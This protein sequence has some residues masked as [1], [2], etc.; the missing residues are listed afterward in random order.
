MRNVKL[1]QLI[2]EI[3]RRARIIPPQGIDPLAAI[4]QH[5]ALL[6]N[7]LESQMLVRIIRA[8]AEGEGEFHENEIWAL[9]PKALG[10]ID[11]LIERTIS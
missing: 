5:C 2:V 8:I 1:A 3:Q 6:P 11:A 9:G 4:K 10:L 7:S